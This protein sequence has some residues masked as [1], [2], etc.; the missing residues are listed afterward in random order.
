V[1]KENVLIDSVELNWQGNAD[2]YHLYVSTLP[3]FK[4]CKPVVISDKNFVKAENE[5][6][7]GWL[8]LILFP[9]LL[10][11]VKK[12][13]AYFLVLIVLFYSECKTH[14]SIIKIKENKSYSY[15]LTNL[16]TNKVYYWKIKAVK[17][18]FPT[19]TSIVKQFSTL[20]TQ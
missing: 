15:V 11:A 6:N 20:L 19:T 14:P 12:R 16:E 13:K 4:T 7:L 3:D 1:N 17:D 9:V 8:I 5:S 18:N 10:M 2:S